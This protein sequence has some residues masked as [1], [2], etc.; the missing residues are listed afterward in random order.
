MI[1]RVMT[2]AA[3]P[4]ASTVGTATPA[5]P[6]FSTKI[7]NALPI[8]LSTFIL[9]ETF[10]ESFVFPCA[11]KIAMPELY[12]ASRGKESAVMEK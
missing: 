4:L 10:M 2:A 7:Q 6:I 3:Y 5:T 1:L 11:R 12:T 8:T 9:S